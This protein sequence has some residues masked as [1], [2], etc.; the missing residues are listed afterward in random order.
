MDNLTD[1]VR[2]GLTGIVLIC[3]AWL[4]LVWVLGPV[5]KLDATS[6]HSLRYGAQ[7]LMDPADPGVNAR[8]AFQLTHLPYVLAVW[9]VTGALSLFI[10]T[11][12]RGSVLGLPVLFALASLAGAFEQVHGWDAAHWLYAACIGLVIGLLVWLKAG[13]YGRANPAHAT[14]PSTAAWIIWS[15]WFVLI[16]LGVIWLGDLANRGPV[17]LRYLG[18]HQLDAMWLAL[19]VVLPLSTW[20]SGLFVR[21]LLKLNQ[22]WQKPTGAWAILLMFCISVMG[23]VWIGAYAK[24]GGQRGYP[25]ISAEFVRLLITL[26]VA[27]LMSR[28]L[29]WG[30]ESGRMRK[31]IALLLL[32]ASGAL[33]V[34]LLTRDMGPVLALAI[35]VI[36]T[37]TALLAF[38]RIVP[39]GIAMMVLWL[40]SGW[41]MQ[42]TLTAWLPQQSWAPER[43]VLR[44]EARTN[45]FSAQ[46]DYAAQIEWVLEAAG[47]D[48]FGLGGVSWCGAEAHVGNRPCTNYSGVPV[49]FASD[50]VHTAMRVVWGDTGALA[51]LSATAL[52]LVAVTLRAVHQPVR[53]GAELSA[54][55]L[56]AWLV[57]LMA[58]MFMGQLVVTVAGNLRIISISGVTQP[59]LG[60]GTTAL[61][62]FAAWLGLALGA[63]SDNPAPA[64]RAPLSPTLSRYALSMCVGMVTFVLLAWGWS[65]SH[66]EQVSDRLI[67]AT[68]VQGLKLLQ[69]ASSPKPLADK[70]SQPQPTANIQIAEPCTVHATELQRLLPR[71]E[72]HTGLPLHFKPITCEQALPLKVAVHWA[73]ARPPLTALT[74]IRNPRP[75]EIGVNN[76]YRLQGC[77]TTAKQSGTDCDTIALSADLT[78]MPRLAQALAALTSGVRGQTHA[79]QP[80]RLHQPPT[81]QQA[82]SPWWAEPLRMQQVVEHLI[83]DRQ[84]PATLL[85]QGKTVAL[86][87]DPSLQETVQDTARCYTGPCDQLTPDQTHAVDMREGARARMV[88]ALVVDVNTGAIDAA[89]TSASPCYTQYH[90]GMS[91]AP[92]MNM[93]VPAANRPWM[94]TNQ[95]LYGVVMGGSTYKIEQSLALLR[96][97]TPLAKD[98]VRFARAIKES[99][100]EQFIDEFMCADQAFNPGCIQQRLNGLVVAT[101]DLGGHTHCP[102][103]TQHCH[104]INL[105]PAEYGV[106]HEVP[107]RNLLTAPGRGDRTAPDVWVPGSKHF[108]PD[109]IKKCHANGQPGRWRHCNGEGLVNL[110]AEL[111]GQGNATTTPVGLAQSL[112]RVAHAANTESEPGTPQLHVVQPMAP[113]MGLQEAI[114]AAHAIRLLRAMQEPIKPGGTAHLACTRVLQ[115]GGALN[116]LNTGSWVMATK[117]GTPLF[118]HDKWPHAQREKYCQDLR[119]QPGAAVVRSPQWAHCVVAPYKWFALL[120]G[121][122]DGTAVH[123][124]KAVVTLAER[125]WNARTGM[126]DTP[127]DRGGNVAAEVGLRVAQHIAQRTERAPITP[128]TPHGHP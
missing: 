126:V 66:K 6:Y 13:Q 55:R 34:L 122:S 98:P 5:L 57:V 60:L 80:T 58:A 3:T 8:A 121:K 59:L 85:G 63:D 103:G 70:N 120:L 7:A 31:A 117:T 107:A 24:L 114:G 73:L 127:F 125:N 106:K 89:A 97:D 100:T 29:E 51:L 23:L 14:G 118:P 16:S 123:W 1:R 28:Y 124:Q 20:G 38:K 105:I 27:W 41:A 83:Q 52:L 25:H 26:A 101:E 50:Y 36:P 40:A 67:P 11:R 77:W 56:T 102:D 109:N 2:T 65:I 93:P 43:V 19:M 76:P 110:V 119:R 72:R 37:V 42:H 48:G 104:D 54:K 18:V 32:A 108:L 33:A 45:P 12:Y 22:W 78:D 99:R 35:A 21:A 71:L 96:M 81:L 91:A 30:A 94:L 69:Q 39:T 87:F 113:S 115:G 44:E 74:Q 88:S 68:V 112:V 17:S 84:P 10:A 46:L 53:V 4:L 111:F 86:T 64:P 92:C 47:P 49:Q 62:A 128:E 82:Q 79:A 90:H 95:A 61:L 15:T 9:L 116:C 75:T